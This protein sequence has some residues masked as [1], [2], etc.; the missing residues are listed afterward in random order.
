MTIYLCLPPERLTSHAAMSRLWISSI[1]R[2]ITPGA[3]ESR[4][5][6]FL[7]DEVGNMGHLQILEDA[8]T[9]FSGMGI[10]LWFIFQS[11]DQVK[12]CFGE[13]ATTFLD[14]IG[15]QQYFSIQSYD[16]ADAIAKRIGEAT[17][18]SVSENDG[19]SDSMPTGFAANGPTPG[20]RTQSRGSTSSEIARKLLKPEEIIGLPSDVQ[21]IFHNNHPPILARRILYYN[22]PLFRFG[23]AGKSRGVGLAG[24]ILCAFLL[25]VSLALAAVATTLPSLQRRHDHSGVSFGKTQGRSWDQFVPPPPRSVRPRSG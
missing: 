24:G 21:I 17:V 13:R 8:V 16:T 18:T 7:L 2:A 25:F 20:S 23:R 1:M 11:L 9:M 15:T 5:T 12:T 22:S 10:R 3:D 4:K 14:N 6:L 19:T